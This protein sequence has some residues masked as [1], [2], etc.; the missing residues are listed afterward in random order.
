MR[1]EIRMFFSI[2]QVEKRHN[3]GLVDGIWT[4]DCSG[5]TLDVALQ[6]AKETT[7]VNRGQDYA[8]IAQCNSGYKAIGMRLRRKKELK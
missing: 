2:I 4:Q 3:D 7:E 5:V 8:V 6:R 1:G